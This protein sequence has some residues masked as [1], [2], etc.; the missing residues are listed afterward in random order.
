MARFSTAPQRSGTPAA[1]RLGKFHP[2]AAHTQH[3]QAGACG[4]KC[5]G[6]E[7][8]TLLATPKK[9]A[10]LGEIPRQQRLAPHLKLQICHS[11]EPKA[12]HAEDDL[13]RPVPAKHHAQRPIYKHKKQPSKQERPCMWGKLLCPKLSRKA[14]AVGPLHQNHV[15]KRQH[16][17]ACDIQP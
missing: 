16:Q 10:K 13:G 11:A 9:F 15:T 17:Q 14:A 5:Q 12:H 2:Y 8:F 6:M 7:R 4:K 3:G 1:G